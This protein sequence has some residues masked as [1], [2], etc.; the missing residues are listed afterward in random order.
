MGFIDAKIIKAGF[1]SNAHLNS[2]ALNLMF[3]QGSNGAM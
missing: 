2:F 1:E 3:A